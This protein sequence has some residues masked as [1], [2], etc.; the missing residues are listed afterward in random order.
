MRTFRLGKPSP[1][2]VISLLALLVALGGTAYAGITIPKNSVGTKQLKNGAVTT[3]K[4]NNGAVTT[5]KIKNGNVTASKINTTGLTVPNALHANHADT[6]TTA[7][8]ATNATN[9]TT[10]T[11]AT[12][13]TNL[14][15]LGPSEYTTASNYTQSSTATPITS[16]VAT[17]GSPI[18]ITTAGTR[19]VIASAAV[20]ATNGVAGTGV[21]LV[22]HIT[23]DGTSGVN[24]T[25]Y[26][27]PAGGFTIVDAAVSPLASAV[28]GAGTHTVTLLCDAVGGATPQATVADD[29]LATWAVSG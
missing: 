22:C 11:N 10:A 27:S 19:R 3:T 13:A 14:G 7:T 4:L 21:Y 20:H 18:Q 15:G 5:K 2:L 9:A 1:A 16:T 29:A 8:T 12:N 23:I 28:V 26:A 24:D 6:A 17:I 25:D